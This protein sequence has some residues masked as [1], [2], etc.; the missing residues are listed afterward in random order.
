MGRTGKCAQNLLYWLVMLFGV[1]GEN[2]PPVL[3][4]A[5]DGDTDAEHFVRRASAPKRITGL[6]QY[7]IAVKG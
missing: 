4:T 7:F 3:E 2:S 6:S 5:R 1:F